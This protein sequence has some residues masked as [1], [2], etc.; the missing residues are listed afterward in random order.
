M[1]FL[2]A[3]KE[4]YLWL[5]QGK[6]NVD[7]RK[8]LPKRGEFAVFQ[9]GPEVLRRRIVAREVGTLAEVVRADNFLNIIPTVGTL[10]DAIAYIR[11]LY[12]AYDG[13]FTAYHLESYGGQSDV[14]L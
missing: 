9:C 8:G 11:G 14:K 3:K 10:K 4:V 5:K 13:V 1:P 2:Y 6:K 7:I 12:P